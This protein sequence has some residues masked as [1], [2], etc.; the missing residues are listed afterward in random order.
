[1]ILFLE[2]N[3]Q[4]VRLPMTIR[5]LLDQGNMSQ[6]EV[7]FQRYQSLL[8]AYRSKPVLSTIISD[9]EEQLRVARKYQLMRLLTEIS[10]AEASR[11]LNLHPSE[12]SDVH[13]Y[14]LHKLILHVLPHFTFTNPLEKEELGRM[15]KEVDHWE[16]REF[17]ELV[18]PG[19]EKGISEEGDLL[20]AFL[21]DVQKE[22]GED[23]WVL[24]EGFATELRALV[25]MAGEWLKQKKID[26]K[27]ILVLAKNMIEWY[28]QRTKHEGKETSCTHLR[29]LCNI[30]LVIELIGKN[31]ESKR[32]VELVSSLKV[33]NFTLLCESLK[34]ESSSNIDFKADE[35][36]RD[37]DK[38]YYNGMLVA[39]MDEVVAHAP[40]LL[41]HP[42]FDSQN[43][44]YLQKLFDFVAGCFIMQ[45]Q[46]LRGL[47]EIL[48]YSVLI[49]TAETDFMRPFFAHFGQFPK[50]KRY[51]EDRLSPEHKRIDELLYTYIRIEYSSTIKKS[52]S[53]LGLVILDYINDS[54][55]LIARYAGIPPLT[56]PATTRS[57]VS[58]SWRPSWWSRT[59]CC[60]S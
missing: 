57:T 35:V 10:G 47:P 28:Q 2:T 42:A 33:N 6:I 39:V 36:R 56:Q 21:E 13:T 24:W 25:E 32:L 5:L 55:T 7:L 27:P 59:R 23:S 54:A 15:Q 1:L 14:L 51:V 41:S 53:G 48:T 3:S 50:L 9:I 12:S 60:E 20:E 22:S 45:D 29:A 46:Q 26:H 34:A 30:L 43:T 40:E 38:N 37:P 31:F 58:S 44:A 52:K 18:R 4:F 17:H 16:L 19:Q 8:M 11:F 49:Y